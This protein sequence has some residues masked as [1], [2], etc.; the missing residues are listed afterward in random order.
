M[1]PVLISTRG[2]HSIALGLP[3]GNMPPAIVGIASRKDLT[4]TCLDQIGSCLTQ[5]K[6]RQLLSGT[7]SMSQNCGLLKR[8]RKTCGDAM[9]LMLCRLPCLLRAERLVRF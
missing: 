7:S 1:W 5:P 3:T 4:E 8:Y 6:D 9:I 2:V